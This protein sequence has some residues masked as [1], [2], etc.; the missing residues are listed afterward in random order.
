MKLHAISSLALMLT[1]G[2]TALPVMAAN[3]KSVHLISH[4]SRYEWGHAGSQTTRL[5]AEYEV[6]DQG[7]D[8]ICEVRYSTDGWRTSAILPATFDRTVGSYERWK[9]NIGVPGF[10]TPFLHVFTCRDLGASYQVYSPVNGTWLTSYGLTISSPVF[11][12]N[13][14]N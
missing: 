13:S 6:R 11:V 1:V 10:R 4:Q 3:L 9:I 14:G 8:H 7:L 5:T 12:A 2:S